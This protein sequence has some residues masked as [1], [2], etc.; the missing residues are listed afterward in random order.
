[1]FDQ[2]DAAWL[3]NVASLPGVQA[4]QYTAWWSANAVG[5]RTLEGI[6]FEAELPVGTG[7]WVIDEIGPEGVSLKRNDTYFQAPPHADRLELVVLPEG[8]ERVSQWEAG[9]LDVVGQLDPQRVEELL[10]DRGRL[11]VSNA[12]RTFFA[13]YNFD[14]PNRY[15]PVV[16]AYPELREAISLSLDRERYAK[17]F[18]GGFLRWEQ[19]GIVAQPWVDDA[20]QKN[21]KRDVKRARKLLKDLGWQDANGDGILDSPYGDAFALTAVVLDTAERAVVDTLKAM[22]TDLQEIGGTIEVNVVSAEEFVAWWSDDHTWDLLV[23]DL[24]LYPAFTE[25]DLIGTDW[26]VRTNPAGWNPGGYSNADADAAI[27]AYFAAVDEK[28]MAA[29]LADLQKAIVEDPF[30]I[31]LGF[32]QDLTLLAPRVKGFVPNPLWPTLDTRLMWIDDTEQDR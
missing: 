31:W 13:A 2:P 1:V 32:P 14:N 9:D 24:R 30:A 12:A 8:D 25:F 3:F 20:S 16:L 27:E 15:E 7:P 11:I 4:A 21:P 6:T 26:N 29:A 18:W 10:Y 5:E 23:Y 28:G 17:E 22:D 19:A